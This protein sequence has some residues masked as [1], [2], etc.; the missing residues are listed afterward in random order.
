VFVDPGVFPDAEDPKKRN[1]EYDAFDDR[2]VSLLLTEIIVVCCFPIPSAGRGGRTVARTW[3]G[4]SV[5][6][7]PGH[8]SRWTT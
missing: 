2:Y 8:S 6:W 5:R 4:V 7:R 1:T 3:P